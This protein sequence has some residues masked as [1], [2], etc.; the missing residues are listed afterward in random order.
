LIFK[1][2]RKPIF[3]STQNPSEPKLLAIFHSVRSWRTRAQSGSYKL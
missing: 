2:R 1:Y 3:P